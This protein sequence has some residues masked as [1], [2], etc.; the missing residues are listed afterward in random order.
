[1][2]KGQGGTSF[3]ILAAC[4]LF[5]LGL[6]LVD[7]WLRGPPPIPPVAVEMAA[8]E[9]AAAAAEV[10]AQG[11]LLPLPPPEDDAPSE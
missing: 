3:K 5:G 9:A 1:M 10:E 11:G 2:V 7:S 4:V 6:A 8:D